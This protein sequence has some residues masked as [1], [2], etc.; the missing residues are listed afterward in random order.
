M[1]DL[2][3][4]LSLMLAGCLI[5]TAILPAGALA[6]EPASGSMV[7]SASAG[8]SEVQGQNQWSYQRLAGGVYND[9]PHYD[10][11]NKRW[12]QSGSSPIYP[13]VKGGEMHPANN[14][15]AV[16][17]WTSPAKGTVEITGEVRKGDNNGDGVN[18]SIK[19]NGTVLWSSLVSGST[20]LVPSGV[21]G[22]AVEAG[23]TITFEI[24][25]NG[26]LNNDHTFWNPAVQFTSQPV[27]VE[28]E[29]TLAAAESVNTRGG[30]SGGVNHAATNQMMKVPAASPDPAAGTE[31]WVK[32][33]ILNG[34]PDLVNTRH[35]YLK[36]DLSAFDGASL[37]SVTL[38]VYGKEELTK[39]VPVTVSGLSGS[40]W[41]ES[42]LTWNNAPAEAGT[43]LG[44][45]TIRSIGWYEYDVTTF[46]NNRLT[47]GEGSVSFRMTDNSAVD[48]NAKFFSTRAA[49][50][51]P[52]LVVKTGQQPVVSPVTAQPPS[53][54]VAAGTQIQLSTQTVGAEI[55]YTLDGSDPVLGGT[56]YSGPFGLN[57]GATVR[58][59][60]KKQGWTPS[61]AASFTYTMLPQVP[62]GVTNLPDSFYNRPG[63]EAMPRIDYAS[64]K[65]AN[66]RDYG[67]TGDGVTDDKA[68][69]DLAIDAL[70]AQGGGVVYMPAGKYFFAP[71]PTNGTTP[72]SRRF[73]DRTGARALNN[74]HFVG[75]GEST[76]IVFRNP[77]ISSVPNGQTYSNS[78]GAYMSGRPYGWRLDGT[79]YSLRGF[80]TSWTPRMDMRSINGPYNLGLSGQNIQAVNLNVDQGGIGMV[81]WQNTR[82][83][84]A[85]GNVVRNTGADSIHFA[86]TVDVVAAYNWVENSNDDA[87]GFVSDAPGTNNWPVSQNNYALYNTIIKTPWGRGIS[88]G[89]IGHKLENNWIESSLLSGIFTNSLGQA[90]E[91]GIPVQD[92]SIKGNTIL[93]SDQNNRADNNNRNSGVYKGS[94][95]LNNNA[96]RVN[97]ENNKIYGNPGNG[98]FFSAWSS[99]LQGKNLSVRN[100][101]IEGSLESAVKINGNA[102]IDGLE[103]TGNSFL[104]NAN[105]VLFGGTL[106]GTLTYSGNRVSQPTVP[107][108][109]GFDVVTDQAEY[110]DLYQTLGNAASE[111]GWAEAPAVLPAGSGQEINVRT[112]G[113]K[114]DGAS[115][116]THAFQ[117]ALDAVPAQG[118]SLYVPAG[119]YKLSPQTGQD[120]LAF[121][122]I[123]HHLAVKA[124]SNLRIRGDGDGSVLRFTSAEH[125]GLRLAGVTGASVQGLKLEL[126]EQPYQRHNRALLDLTGSTG[127]AVDHVTAVNSGGPGIL[128]DTS[129]RVSVKNSTVTNAGTGGVEILASRQVFVENNTVQN[130][131]DSAVLVNK[132]GT[133]GREPQYIRIAGNQLAG[134][135]DQSGVSIASGNQI[136]VTGNTITDTHLAGIAVYYTSEA[137]HAEKV[138]IQNNTLTRT[139]QGSSTYHYGAITVLRS[140]KGDL[141]ISGNT[142]DTT[143]YFG[144]ALDQSTLTRLE[145][146]QNIFRSLGKEPVRQFNT[147]ISTQ[148]DL[149]KLANIKSIVPKLVQPGAWQHWAVEVEL[150]NRST[151]P[152]SGTAGLG[153]T[154]EWPQPGAAV[155]LASLAPGTAAKLLL[156]VPLPPD[157][158]RVE[159]EVV[160]NLDTGVRQ[161][162]VQ[163]V[164]FL[165]AKRAV[166][167]IVPDGVVGGEWAGAMPFRLAEAAQYKNVSGG[168]VP[169]GGADDLS[170]V[171]YT[172][173]DQDNLYLAAV[174]KDNVHRQAS[175]DGA[176]WMGDSIQF[177][178]DHGRLAG[179]GSAGYTELLF[180]RSDAG[181]TVKWRWSGVAGKPVGALAA[182]QASIVR[183]EAE[184]TTV[185]EVAVPWS[186]LLPAGVA[187]PETLVGF[188]FLVNDDDG[189]GRHGWLE[190]MS[191]IGTGKNPAQF[192]E[193]VLS[194]AGGQPPGDNVPPV[195]TLLGAAEMELVQGTAFVEPGFSAV[196][197]TD[198]D[199]TPAVVVTGSVDTAVPGEYVLQY[200][201]RDQAGNQAVAVVRTVRVVEAPYPFL[202][203]A[204]GGLQRAS[205]LSATVRIHREDGVPAPA[206]NAV[207]VFQLMRGT[208]P[209]SYVA[210]SQLFDGGEELTGHFDVADPGNSAYT[211]HVLMLD[212]LNSGGGTGMPV[213][214]S[215]KV[216]LE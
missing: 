113:A 26:N 108:R 125:Q 68:A 91:S 73:W 157:T 169:W 129:T 96:T 166:S 86:N 136:E 53:G 116:D 174:V 131:R 98:I 42:T 83:V 140:M 79:N 186:E 101:R 92:V 132:L 128:V 133:I 100:N 27:V 168:T 176:A 127:V 107:V 178:I 55:Y 156:P 191:G 70:N 29:I 46:V 14:G 195:I 188:S 7:Y 50:N 74:I 200:N 204:V 2:K 37:N 181:D 213:P 205:G 25:R 18:A 4:R 44:T 94:V 119:V 11:A 177:M 192:G 105:S 111:T 130:S 71:T 77:G 69:F 173:W 150:E 22:I 151:V 104:G 15:D 145:L 89:G 184:R 30:S 149:D 122:A 185:Y 211:V 59:Y 190:Y 155:P 161:S 194:P 137:F 103:M 48:L 47:A 193:L 51:R 207:V 182:A 183:N 114:G 123:G 65:V 163:P 167:L 41:Q 64:M 162:V 87:V 171:G 187:I 110:V 164:N 208:T 112:F 99:A 143:P 49:G 21:S 120:K 17:T 10:T 40:A 54:A 88:A 154:A 78:G 8:F 6:E 134:S 121:T 135:R 76:V 160:V 196:D 75:D 97:I 82:N 144:I 28:Q 115:D 1:T 45:Q 172:Q 16:R 33:R 81:F 58:A 32:A 199:L 117:A 38:R 19:R 216:V 152:I 72:E 52:E 212:R 198:G 39:D 146:G 13:W 209:V 57:S 80:S 138:R 170:A 165:A 206:G 5:L 148:V 84:W 12:Q 66:V 210:S 24:N 175:S 126:A 124:K 85:V 34:S 179:P 197:E 141:V 180:A 20:P 3:R 43:P 139:N 214:L 203:E 62:S 201:V 118:G 159:L 61:Q 95:V 35:G 109:T 202:L 147:T 63:L 90:G 60:A 215:P 189:P 153:P 102:V 158:R 56:L 106:R 142:V 31:F 67:A 36:F 23:D 93:R 9:L